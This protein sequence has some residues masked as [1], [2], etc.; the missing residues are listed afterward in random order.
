MAPTKGNIPWNKGIKL[1]PAQRAKL[2]LDHLHKKGA[3]AS[4]WKGGQYPCIDCG[5]TLSGHRSKAKENT[6]CKPCKDKFY[7]GENHPNYKMGGG[8]Y[9]ETI[10]A[11]LRK[12]LAEGGHSEREWD[13]LKRKYNFSCLCCKKQEPFVKL[14]RDHI[15]PIMRGGSDDIENIQ[16]LCKSCNSRKHIKE[17]DYK[18]LWTPSIK[19]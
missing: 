7:V 13:E 16:P 18:A 15:I 19:S 5:K 11:R 9:R 1:T 12:L 10:I 6:R 17:I 4:H 14:T 8:S 2:N 3:A